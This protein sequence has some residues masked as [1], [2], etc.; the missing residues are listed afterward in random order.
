MCVYFY[1]YY[2]GYMTAPEENICIPLVKCAALALHN[3]KTN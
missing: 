2:H 3:T 1:N